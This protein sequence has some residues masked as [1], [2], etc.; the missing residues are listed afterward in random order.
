MASSMPSKKWNMYPSSAVRSV[1]CRYRSV[2]LEH[3]ELE[4]I[5]VIRGQEA[6]H[7]RYRVRR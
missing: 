3:I 6:T 5:Q 4:T 2:R 1:L 7:L